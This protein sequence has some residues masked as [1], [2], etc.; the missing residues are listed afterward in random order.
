MKQIAEYFPIWDQ[1]SEEEQHAIE[2][3]AVFRQVAAGETVH[4]GG[5]DC[6][7]LLLLCDGRH[8]SLSHRGGGL[9]S[10]LYCHTDE[11]YIL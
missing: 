3:N 10:C 2:A 5:R 11:V 9:N 4:D 6:T 7:A 8:W 1:L